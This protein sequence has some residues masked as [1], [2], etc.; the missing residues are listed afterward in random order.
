[1]NPTRSDPTVSEDFRT[2]IENAIAKVDDPCS[3]AANAP[4]SV[5]DLGLVR[6]WHL[7]SEGAVIVTVS[8]TAPSCV[9]MASIA[10]GIEARIAEVEG[11]HAVRVEIDTVTMWTPDLMTET[12]RQTLEERRSTSLIS[13]PIYPRQ[14]EHKLE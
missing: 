3:I 4:M 2:A 11:V 7:D 12:G 10:E 5:L 14:W 8:P 9:L 13:V 1:M 6:E